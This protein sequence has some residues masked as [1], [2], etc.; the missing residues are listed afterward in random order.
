MHKKYY[1]YVLKSL[2]DSRRYIGY[3]ENFERR[4]TEHNNGLVKSTRNR[5]PFEL[6]YFEEFD[7]K[8]E[9]LIREKFFKSGKG[10]KYLSTI[11]TELEFLK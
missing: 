3:T 6:I 1:V 2:K 11:K 8:T 5:R 10:R 7:N 9:A 4:I